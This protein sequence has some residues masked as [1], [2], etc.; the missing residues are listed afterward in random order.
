MNSMKALKKLF[1]YILPWKRSYFSGSIVVAVS[2]YCENMI[3][4]LLLGRVLG[5]VTTGTFQKAIS[6]IILYAVLYLLI[7]LFVAVGNGISNRD[8]MFATQN[9][10][11]K[12]F[13]RI[14]NSKLSH[15]LNKHL[16]DTLTRLDSDVNA[17]SDVF[18][19]TIK[20]GLSLVFTLVASI[21]TVFFVSWISGVSLILFGLV[22]L[23]INIKF[24]APA[25]VRYKI[26]REHV[27]KSVMNM[28]DLLS[29]AKL[30]RF[31]DEKSILL[32][33]YETDCKTLQEKKMSA[34]KLT[35]LQNTLGQVQASFVVLFSIGIGFLLWK[36]N[37]ISIEQIPILQNMGSML[38]TPLSSI[39]FMVANMQNSL[40]GGVRVLEL[41]DMPQEELK[42]ERTHSVLSTDHAVSCNQLTFG[43]HDKTVLDK[44]SFTLPRGKMLAVVGE[45]GSGK[46]TL[47]KLLM[48]LYE[49][50]GS[51]TVLGKEV[52]SISPVEVR[53][54]T[55]YV[56]Q[57]CP[58]FEGT[59]FENISLGRRE[60]SEEEV[61]KAA[62]KAGV[63]EFVADFRE[64]FSTQVGE[65]G[66]KLSG[67]QRQKISIARALLKDAPIM[68]FDE[69][70]S[71]IDSIS[72]QYIQKTIESLKEEKTIVVVAHRLSTIREA[73]C[74]MVMDKGKLVEIGTHEELNYKRGYYARLQKLQELVVD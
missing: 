71:S 26:A 59:I 41:V 43:Y 47:L 22:M 42:Q 16:G 23:W 54:M 1:S 66:V 27:A 58:L 73:D 11:L 50:N 18:K 67:G 8:A 49:Y 34:I 13:T 53:N 68:L 5:A 37:I 10:R 45:S 61:Y 33:R 24:I 72:E 25:R 14:I 46:S 28:S 36:N 44:L 32:D 55:A 56:P 64:G 39:G 12:A 4:A 21:I 40:T 48:G 9:I 7:L 15:I 31:Y 57:D 52:S 65:S 29:N 30:L 2:N 35:T 63:I 20:T 19:N 17:S 69:I 74:I 70:T 62:S 3:M 51:L 38:V 6:D 60:A